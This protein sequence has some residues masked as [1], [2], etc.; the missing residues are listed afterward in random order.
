MQAKS[1]LRSRGKAV[2]ALVFALL[3]CACAGLAPAPSTPAET[4]VVTGIMAGRASV[5]GEKSFVLRSAN[6]R[7]FFVSQVT[8]S[9]L[10]EGDVVELERQPN[11]AARIRER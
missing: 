1:S 7:V 4:A 5:P 10:K 6:G 8:K 11:G 2:A 3:L 9:P